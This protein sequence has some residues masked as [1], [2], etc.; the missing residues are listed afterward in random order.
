MQKGE[1][2][3]SRKNNWTDMAAKES[4]LQITIILMVT[5]PKIV[6]TTLLEFPVYT[7]K[8]SKES[9]STQTLSRKK[10]DGS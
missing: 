9:T 8:S 10:D 1:D 2:S 4:A 5:P 7:D 6:A 3:N